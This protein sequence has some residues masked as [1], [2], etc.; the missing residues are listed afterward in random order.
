MSSIQTPLPGG[1][2]APAV[3]QASAGPCPLPGS[4][5]AGWCPW[6]L[7]TPEDPGVPVLLPQGAWPPQSIKGKWRE[8]MALPEPARPSGKPRA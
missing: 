1:N 6:G 3:P 2:P 4:C 7:Q 5:T 8:K